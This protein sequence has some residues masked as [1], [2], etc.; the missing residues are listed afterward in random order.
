M[1]EMTQ[2]S[3]ATQFS[4]HGMIALVTID[5]PPV[6]ALSH[7]VRAGLVEAVKRALADDD[8]AALVVICGGRTFIAGADIKEFG[9][10]MK[11]PLIHEVIAAI[12][13]SSKPVIA[14]IHGTAL[15]GGFELA[16][17]C[18]YRVAVAGAEIGLPEVK[19]GIIPGAGGTQRL[20]R[21][22]GVEAALKMIVDGTK[23]AAPQ[24]LS[25]GALDQII[26]L[27]QSGDLRSGAIAYAER[28]IAEKR[29]LRKT[30]ELPVRLDNPAIFDEMRNVVSKRQRGFPA[31]LKCIEAVK[32]AVDLPFVEASKLEY[33]LCIQMLNSP[34]SQAQRQAFA[35]EREVVRIC[36][37]DAGTQARTIR[38]VAVIGPGTMGTGIAMC[39]INADLRVMLLGRDEK[40]L[41]KSV[42]T[43][44][45]IY[46]GSVSKGSIQQAAMDRRLALLTL[47]TEYR[48]LHEVDLVI[49]AVSEDMAVKKDVFRQLDAA[50]K[51]DAILATNTSYLNIDDLAA[52][53]SRPH[54]VVGTHFFNPAN[55][56]RLLENVRGAQTSPDVLATVMKMAKT[57]GK[58]A[59]MV[60]MSDG[61]VG[62]RMLGKRSRE[63][64]FMMEEGATPWQIDKVLYDFGF[65][66][67]PYQV[68]DLAGLDVA[69]AARK[70]RFERLTEREKQCNIL[71]Q[72]CATGRF[73]QK[74][75]AG[76]YKYDDKRNA[77]PDPIIE[78]LIA[79]H[80][81]RRGIARRPISDQEIRERCLFAMINEGAK[82]LEEGVAARAQDIDVIWLHGFGFPAYRGGPMFYA[83]QIGLGNVY[84][85]LLKY[86][87]QVGEE[88]FTPASL[89][90][91]LAKEGKGFYQ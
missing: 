27:D 3:Q 30:S 36:G 26:D 86:R 40:S 52:V 5:N 28:V 37:I 21:L 9:K 67:G 17:A 83:D 64:F 84:D 10:P 24:A 38:S 45:K 85:A 87:D 14:A 66:M 32:F 68:A 61:F 34:E 54:D 69:W 71:D 4:K 35:S 88:Y 62:N 42:Q 73:G 16:M 60:G 41:A 1:M 59:T 82:I 46:S 44:R 15:G 22:V 89:L 49:E 78:A 11:P 72:I 12:E 2:A 79:D 76:Y 50:C 56:M 51:P 29:P 81:I 18:H 80:S 74:T 53:T 70:A 33:E 55:V 57:I 65:P 6:N 63:G 23:I 48:D 39:F 20:P 77:T 13:N 58:V 90:E 43:M 19:L 75:G 47:T 8:T 91:R 25:M 31:P 7:A